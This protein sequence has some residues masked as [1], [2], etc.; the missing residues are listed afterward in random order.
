MTQNHPSARAAD[1]VGDPVIVVGTGIAG[2]LTALE[3][4]RH[5]EVLVLGKPGGERGSTA[6][7]QGG[8]AAAVGPDDSPRLHARDTI[9]AGDGLCDA[10]AVT[11]MCAAGPERLDALAALGVRFDGDEA[12]PALA[13]E[14]AHSRARV[15]HAG[16]DATGARITEAVVAAVRASGRAH[17]ALET[18]VAIDVRDGRARG[19]VTEDAA[20]RRTRRGARAVVLAT[21]GLGAVFARTTNPPTATGDGPALAARA[22]AALCDMEFVQFHP[23]ALAVGEGGLPLVT[24]AIR[25]EGAVLRDARGRRF[26]FDVHPMGE[27]GPRD[28]VA[29][30]IAR[31]AAE[32]GRPVTLHLGHLDAGAVTARFPAVAAICAR[33]G[34]DLARDP[35]PVTPAAHYA[36]GGV[37]TDLAGRSTLPGLYAVGECAATG[38]HG[39]NRLASNSLLEAAVMAR[40]AAAALLDESGEWPDRGLPLGVPR[41]APEARGRDAAARAAVQALAWEGLG[42]ERDGADIAATAR[43]LAQT[44]VGDVQTANMRECALAI[45]A[46][47]ARRT[48]SRGA[49]FRS[50][51]PAADPAQAERVAFVGGRAHP[52]VTTDNTT[53]VVAA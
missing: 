30:A 50:D 16:G 48:E 22:G 44:P 15:A 14:G 10:D 9:A 3:L 1:G 49:H 46:A 31:R 20:G 47:A 25:G 53:T 23:T 38:V 11:A 6:W 17:R 26:L 45:A 8:I 29:R 28:V 43:S 37:L 7:A 33:H 51:A 27:L 4:A 18:A 42:V 19:V 5:E 39:A 21:G 36:V 41:P 40:L 52:L 13:R 24:E 2:A 34:L 32:D 12:G 35:I